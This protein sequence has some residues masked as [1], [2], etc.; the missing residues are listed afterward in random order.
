L[1]FEDLNLKKEVARALEGFGF[2]EATW[3]Q[4]RVIPPALEGRDVIGEAPTGSGKTLAFAI[5]IAEKVDGSGGVQALVVTPTRELA[6][7]VSGV[8]A[9]LTRFL[10]V[11]VATVYGGVALEPQLRE[12][13]SAGIVVGTPGRLLDHMRRGTLR[14]GKVRVLVLDEADRM[15]DMGFIEDVQRIIRSTPRSRQT[16]LFSATIP[17]PV[18]R[19][20]ARFMRS[21]LHIRTQE[22]DKPEI[23]EG[24]V[25]VRDG[26]K[27]QLLLALLEAEEPRSAIVFCNTKL[28]ASVLAANLKRHGVGAAAIH[29]DLS[30]ARRERVM[31]D[32]R[33]GRLRVLVATDVA[34]RGIDIP[35][36]SHVFNY[37]IPAS[38]DD[39]THR[40]GRTARAG[41][42]GKAL[43]LLSPSQHDDMRRVHR[44]FP[45]I[46]R[47]EF[48]ADLSRY[49]ALDHRL[50]RLP[51]R[52]RRFAARPPRRD[53]RRRR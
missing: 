25:E 30:Q 2:S 52:R 43:C 20:A 34:A 21:Y 29:G 37:D 27:F 31:A 42:K 3:I 10:G 14:L 6:L 36:V 53:G 28:M 9:E 48:E 50:G 40:I 39:Y 5:P 24:F 22:N 32:F 12:L 4:A 11:Q 35:A 44:S 46:A 45:H 23:E 33:S 19:L 41:A 7:Q 17:P 38:A 16:L 51:R 18:R 49:P 13:K 15:L 47:R 26:E 1:K 8:I